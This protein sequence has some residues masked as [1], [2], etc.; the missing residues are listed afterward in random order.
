M[1]SENVRGYVAALDTSIDGL[2]EALQPIFSTLLEEKIAQCQLPQEQIKIYNS[3]LYITISILYSYIKVLG[4]NTNDH[5]IMNELKRIKE[6]M[7]AVKD[8]EQSL[9]N[10][11]E[12]DLKSQDEAKEFLQRTLGTKVGAAVTESM[13]SPAIS[14]LNFRGTHTKFKDNDKPAAS[15]T[16]DKPSTSKTTKQKPS[17]KVT[18]PQ[19]GKKADR[20]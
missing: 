9:K 4:I 18:K 8:A 10:K 19:R 16:T 17:G 15:K 2:T 1:D 6:V 7:K 13:K 3:H 14:S 12:K 11:D 20:S 5:P